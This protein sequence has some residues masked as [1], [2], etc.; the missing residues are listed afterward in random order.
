MDIIVRAMGIFFI[1]LMTL[2]VGIFL[3]CI[4]EKHDF[5][6]LAF[7]AVSAM[8]TVGLTL[9]ITSSLTLGGKIII[10]LLMFIGR[11]GIMTLVLSLF[12]HHGKQKNNNV[13]YPNGSII[14]G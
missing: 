1:N 2:L 9:G 13:V 6:E 12:S 10:I 8:A 4:F 11:I 5:I 7:E 14:V 3:L